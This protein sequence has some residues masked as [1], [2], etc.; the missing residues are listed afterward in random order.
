MKTINRKILWSITNIIKNKNYNFSK[1]DILN[2]LPEK[3]IDEAIKSISSWKSY[4]ST[5]LIRLN[6]LSSELN[7]GEIYYKDES[8][9]F[10]LKS[11][12]A[13]GGAFAVEKIAD[14]RKDII[15]STATAG[16]HGRSVAWG[17]KKLGLKCKIFIS[18]NVS[19]ARA[20]A[21]KKFGA[22]V[23][24]VKGN[25]D[26]SLKECIE[27][28]K[29]NNWKI[30]QDV[31]WNNY[32]YVPQL[33]MAGYCLMV[34]E[35]FNQI[36]KNKSLTHVFLQAG[37]GGMAAAI[38]AGIA[39]Y[40][41]KI[42][43]IIIVEPDK[44]DCILKSIRKKK[45]IKIR[46]SDESI[47]GGMSCGEVSKVAWNILNRSANYCVSIPDTM[48][49][50][51]AFLLANKKY[52]I[53]KIEAGECATPGIIALKGICFNQ[54]LR[55]EV[56]LNKNSNVLVFGCEGATDKQMYNKLLKLGK[57]LV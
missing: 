8:K 15:V 21:I 33:I 2:F 52:S 48:V 41:K 54:K 22:K 51:V 53:N 34:K 50:P 3:I 14:G 36:K 31:S 42:P 23:I 49:A 56:K 26:N 47:M 7:L 24:R 43:K 37:V 5:P 28:S 44:A 40:S 20:K 18:E 6:K 1:T 39:K 29:K 11:F 35:I 45:P 25:Y 10:S 57:K 13:L 46:I 30:V 55:N 12:K 9:R 32:E 16:N 17:S 19:E 38:V 27:Q 4:R